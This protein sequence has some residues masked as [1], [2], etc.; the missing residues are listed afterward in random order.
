MLQKGAL[1]SPVRPIFL[2]SAMAVGFLPVRQLCGII[3]DIAYASIVLHPTTASRIPHGTSVPIPKGGLAMKR[4]SCLHEPAVSVRILNLLWL[5]FG[6]A[7]VG[8]TFLA[9]LGKFTGMEFSLLQALNPYWMPLFSIFA[10]LT[11]SRMLIECFRAVGVQFSGFHLALLGCAILISAAIYAHCVCSRDILYFW[12]FAGSYV[13]QLE[14]NDAFAAGIRS[15][16]STIKQSVWYGNYAYFLNLFTAVPFFFTRQTGDAYVLG[17]FVSIVP[18]ILAL[19]GALTCKLTALLRVQHSRLF[20]ALGLFSAVCFPLF[21]ASLIFGQGDLLGVVFALA[22]VLLTINYT[23]EKTEPTRLVLLACFAFLVII[24]RRWYIM[25][26]AAYFL[27]YGIF[28]LICAMMDRDSAA[29]CGRILRLLGYAA[30]CVLLIGLI[31]L[32]FI[33]QQ[34]SIDYA[35]NYGAYLHGGFSGELVNQANWLGWIGCAL[36]LVGLIFGYVHSKTRGVALVS[37]ASLLLSIFLFTRIQNMGYHQSLLLIPGYTMLLLLG[38]AAICAI[39]KAW[40]AISAVCA[41]STTL[42]INLVG[43]MLRLSAIQSSPL[44]SDVSLSPASRNDVAEIRGVVEWLLARCV[45]RDSVYIIPHSSV[46]NPSIFRCAL[47]PDRRAFDVIDYG[48][49]ILG[50]HKFP[51]GLL[52]AEYMLTCEPFVYADLE[53]KYNDAFLHGGY[54]ETRF[55]LEKTFDMGN[56]YTFYV[57]RRMVP[58]DAAEIRVYRDILVEENAQYPYLY[59]DV[60]DSFMKERGLLP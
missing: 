9:Y 59:W 28:V 49:A 5:V 46:Y 40:I 14:L 34:S 47:L 19:I 39:P 4:A 29:R 58:A 30:I 2:L 23:F 13:R 16:L 8:G 56:G 41:V 57:Y 11:L 38:L 1:G 21:H 50:E 35:T 22:V 32:P 25:W 36:L 27:C 20:F 33:R 7:A 54:L 3:I 26:A 31:M 42:A 6:L 43:S 24:T 51:T 18:Y 15:G 10:H 45:E 12:D 17:A 37:V 53:H 44:F 48:A 52:T 60:I 55:A